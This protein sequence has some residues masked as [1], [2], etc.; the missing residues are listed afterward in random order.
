MKIRNGFEMCKTF[1][2][3]CCRM[4]H[5]EWFE[6]Q[7]TFSEGTGCYK[8]KFAFLEKCYITAPIFANFE[9]FLWQ[10]ILLNCVNFLCKLFWQWKYQ[11]YEAKNSTL[12]SHKP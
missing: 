7:P 1:D 3:F 6:S 5:F 8:W 2:E 4:C 12:V 11:F 9:T 10:L